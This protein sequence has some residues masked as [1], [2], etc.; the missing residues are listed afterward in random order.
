MKDLRFTIALWI[1]AAAGLACLKIG[2]PTW[3]NSDLL[4]ILG[5]TA[6]IVEVLTGIAFRFSPDLGFVAVHANAVINA[7]CAG[8]NFLIVV[9]AFSMFAALPRE[10]S[11][12]KRVLIAAGLLCAGYVLVVAVNGFRIAVALGIQ[13]SGARASGTLHLCLGV[14][15]FSF[16]LMLYSLLLMKA[17]ERIRKWTMA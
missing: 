5:P 16:F 1:A 11:R 2:Y 17:K 6:G 12:G 3:S 10:G 15:I 14:F 9:I 7:G 8:V 4:W 13:G